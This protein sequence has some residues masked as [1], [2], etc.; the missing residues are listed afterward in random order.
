MWIVRV[1]IVV[2]R[3]GW[4]SQNGGGWRCRSHPPTHSTHP[5]DSA[6][7]QREGR[8]ACEACCSLLCGVHGLCATKSVW[9]GRGFAVG[10][11]TSRCRKAV[12]ECTIQRLV[13]GRFA[14]Q[15]F[16]DEELWNRTS[17]AGGP[18]ARP[19]RLW[20]LSPPARSPVP[21]PAFSSKPTPFSLP[22]TPTRPPPRGRPPAR[23]P[24]GGGRRHSW[25]QWR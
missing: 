3:L 10:N 24:T 2:G 6:T 19:V 15:A 9:R 20:R 4:Q 22:P 16:C 14:I 13:S 21:S 7:P 5:C 23:C 11:A 1:W 8:K 12:T 25:R 17:S 18:P